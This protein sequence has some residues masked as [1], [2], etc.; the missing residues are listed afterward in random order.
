MRDQR[1][2]FLN[3]QGLDRSGGGV[4]IL[5][6]LVRHLA[7]ANRVTVCAESRADDAEHDELGV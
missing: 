3:N 2:L 4:T 7:R 6:H 1:V 5:R